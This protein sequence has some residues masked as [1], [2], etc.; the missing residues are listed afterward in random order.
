MT[1]NPP[2]QCSSFNVSD[3]FSHTYQTIGKI[4]VLYIF[5]NLYMIVETLIGIVTALRYA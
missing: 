3:H 1:E 5:T 2:S 4:I